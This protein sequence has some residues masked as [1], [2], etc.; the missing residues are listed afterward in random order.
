MNDN[1]MKELE[2][3]FNK[4]G[5]L[6]EKL[7]TELLNE[8]GAYQRLLNFYDLRGKLLD[9]NTRQR[10]EL[11]AEVVSLRD[12]LKTSNELLEKLIQS[13]K[14]LKGGDVRERMLKIKRCA[15]CAN[16]LETLRGCLANPAITIEDDGI[17]HPA[18]PLPETL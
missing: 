17:I 1:T 9:D 10:A 7:S 11:M 3:S 13:A 16:H 8:K 2:Y 4:S 14:K 12:K 6:I 18:C 5:E 15:F